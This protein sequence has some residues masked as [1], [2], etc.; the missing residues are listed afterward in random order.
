MAATYSNVLG[1]SNL[2]GSSRQT[3]T[4]PTRTSK[5]Q[6]SSL[7]QNS[8]VPLPSL[9]EGP[10]P[11][12]FYPAI[13]HFTDAITALPREYRRHTSLLKEVDA[14]AWQPEENIQI[15]LEQC[16]S[17]QPLLPPPPALIHS[18]AGSTANLTD[19][20]I[21]LSASNSVTGAIPDA[22]SQI[23]NVSSTA[24]QRRQLFGAL[25]HNLVQIMVTMDEKNHVI[26]NANE[27]LSR[28]VR[29]LDNV[30][31]HI[32]DEISEEA[33]LG[34]LKH[35]AYTDINPTKRATA[36]NTRREAAAMALAHD[37]EAAQRSESRREAVAA[38][39]KQR[40]D[41][42]A[43]LE[44]GLGEGRTSKKK[45]L[46]REEL[47]GN[48]SAS[49]VAGLGILAGKGKK[50][51][52]AG[53]AAMEKSLSAAIGGRTMSREP[54]QQDNK[55]RKAPTGGSAVA[56][57]RY[58][59]HHRPASASN[60]FSRVNAAADS[61]KLASS[62]L[63][64]T[65]PKDAYKRS[66]ALT[67]ARPVSSRA[68][69]NSAHGD[70]PKSKQ[71]FT[72]NRSTLNVPGIEA[73]S[74]AASKSKSEAKSNGKDKT[75]SRSDRATDDPPK[76]RDA[77]RVGQLLERRVSKA[78]EADDA[79]VRGS[80][81]NSPRLGHL[82]IERSGRGRSSK[83]NTPVVGTFHEADSSGS[84]GGNGGKGA[85]GNTNGQPKRPPR[86]RPKYDGLHDSLSPKGLPPKRLHKKGGSISI[87]TGSQN[88]GGPQRLK[89]E[90]STDGPMSQTGSGSRSGNATP[91][92]DASDGEGE[93][94][95]AAPT[96][97]DNGIHGTAAENDDDM[98]VDNED[99][100]IADADEAGRMSPLTSPKAAETR[101]A[102]RG[103]NE[104]LAADEEEDDEEADDQRYCYCQ[105]RSYGEMVACDNDK[106][107][108]EW[109]HL[110][111]VGLKNVPGEDEEWYCKEC[112]VK[113]GIAGGA[114]ARAR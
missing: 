70:L 83:T 114:R 52:K 65:F 12:G 33:R 66:P 46:I 42:T 19:E 49:E 8:L 39:T 73:K 81:A 18:A 25:R 32:A 51:A 94:S 43:Q 48:D 67:A 107:P 17:D 54:S 82:N 78:Q 6:G 56:R 69:Q 3:R 96:Q 86:A 38:K 30:W 74:A 57:K 14:K 11:H 103:R 44:T 77:F 102:V 62:P 99:E 109:F 55:K 58:N 90:L 89:S 97:H 36:A 9:Q 75:M 60:L 80:G 21:H 100:S 10:E 112:K 26:N 59:P 31:P 34:S 110:G 64:S 93:M 22:A 95:A 45:T 37:N 87:T 7:R 13:Q 85:T 23:S 50:T 113:M 40:M 35:W 104:V 88:A 2:R 47:R 29:R 68:R 28:H 72:S 84:Q 5:T 71:A 91:R 24:L 79:S 92:D 53:G 106:C 105:M 16:L 111:C 108:R 4:N 63:A 20:A 61:P 1:T 27:E 76:S 15:L 101:G 41:R 98:M